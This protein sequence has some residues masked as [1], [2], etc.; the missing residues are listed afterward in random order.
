MATDEYA[1]VTLAAAAFATVL[2]AIIKSPQVRDALGALVSRAL[3]G[4]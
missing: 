2:I 3:N 1:L 4:G